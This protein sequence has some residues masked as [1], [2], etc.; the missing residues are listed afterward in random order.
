M[1][2]NDDAKIGNWVWKQSDGIV[3][4]SRGTSGR[5]HTLQNT[6]R[7]KFRT[8]ISMSALDPNQI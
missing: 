2:A 8:F 5:L 7:G 3:L 4:E 6:Q 1:R